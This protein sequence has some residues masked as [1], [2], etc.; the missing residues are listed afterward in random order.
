MRAPVSEG[1][2]KR[3]SRRRG[4]TGWGTRSDKQDWASPDLR[5]ILVRLH[6]FEVD[7]CVLAER[8]CVYVAVCVRVREWVQRRRWWVWTAC[9]VR[10]GQNNKALQSHS[11]WVTLS[12]PNP[13][14]QLY[15]GSWLV[16]PGLICWGSNVPSL[17]AQVRRGSTFVTTPLKCTFW[18]NYFVTWMSYINNSQGKQQQLSSGL[19]SDCSFMLVRFSAH[20]TEK[21]NINKWEQ[22][23]PDW[24]QMWRTGWVEKNAKWWWGCRVEQNVQVI[25]EQKG[26]EWWFNQLGLS[27]TKCTQKQRQKKQTGNH[28]GRVA[29]TNCDS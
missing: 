19:G 20:D 4:K 2:W 6:V 23:Q 22:Q 5:G 3:G 18:I 16:W 14:L 1:C 24:W 15:I 28:V 13:S 11:E 27:G 10:A 21:S 12:P 9:G 25:T 8:W 7:L 26:T 29:S 17:L